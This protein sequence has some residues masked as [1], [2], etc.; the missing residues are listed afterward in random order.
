[1]T[2]V[3]YPAQACIHELF[4]AQVRKS[5]EAVAV[6]YEEKEL[7]YAE[8]NSRA[9]QL[10]HYLRDLGVRPDD[11]VAIFVERSLEMIVGLLGILKAG[12]A[13]VPLDSEY[14]FERLAYMLKDSAPVALLT[15]STLRELVHNVQSTLPVLDLTQ[16]S[17]AW[18]NYPTTNPD[19]TEA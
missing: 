12:G 16:P 15:Q 4:E 19:P 13:Y 10:A 18:V 3:E 11:R 9:N 8:L 17:P 14:P 7:T 6:V 1:D 2:K 5:P